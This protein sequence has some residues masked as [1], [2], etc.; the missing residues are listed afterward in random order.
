M[1]L[2]KFILSFL[3]TELTPSTENAEILSLQVTVPIEENL[4]I[5]P[6][7]IQEVIEWCYLYGV[8]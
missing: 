1:G 6:I 7:N 2:S 3:L 4:D 8:C 5:T